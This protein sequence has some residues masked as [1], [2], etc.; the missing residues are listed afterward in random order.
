MTKRITAL[1]PYTSAEASFASSPHNSDA[2]GM[3]ANTP[4]KN[5]IKNHLCA[6]QDNTCFYCDLPLPIGQYDPTIEHIICK[7]RFPDF[8][9]AP[10][11]II[12][13]CS[14][15]NEAKE[16]YCRKT[17]CHDLD[18]GCKSLNP[19]SY[20]STSLPCSNSDYLIVH[21]YFD[22][23]TDHIQFVAGLCVQAVNGSQKGKHTIEM[24]A[25]TREKLVEQRGKRSVTAKMMQRFPWL[26][27]SLLLAMT[28]DPDL[29]G[30]INTLLS[31]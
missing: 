12:V 16:E 19:R 2:W 11:N 6:V 28:D 23:Y 13:C 15:C 7:K 29:R 21:P 9:F 24:Y 4:L 20:T 26:A 8:C 14:H 22:E 25:L 27:R 1:I 3:R 31:R 17:G 30:Q 18:V 10:Q 5:K